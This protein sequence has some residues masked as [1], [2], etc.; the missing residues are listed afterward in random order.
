LGNPLDEELLHYFL[1][2]DEPYVDQEVWPEGGESA[3]L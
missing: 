3:G 2:D 1:R